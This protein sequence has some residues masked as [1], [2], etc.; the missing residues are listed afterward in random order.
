MVRHHDQEQL[1][2]ERVDFSLQ[3]SGHTPSLRE[4]RSETQDRNLKTGTEAGTTRNAAHWLAPCG[5]LSLLSYGT[6]DCLS[7]GGTPWPFP[8]HSLIMEMH[9]RLASAVDN[10]METSLR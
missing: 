7:R 10:L 8:H 6:Q 2:E 1:G 4:V 9:Y 5:L 3:L